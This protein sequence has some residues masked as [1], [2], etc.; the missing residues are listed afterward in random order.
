MKKLFPLKLF[1][2]GCGMVKVAKAYYQSPLGFIEITGTEKG[3]LTLDFLEEVPKVEQADFCLGEALIQLDEYFQG[4]RKEFTLPL[5]L[6]GTEFQK[7][8]WQELQRIPYGETKSYGE[9]AKAIGKQKAA[10]AVGNANNKNK[11]AIFIPCHRVVGSNGSLTGYASGLWRK[12]WLLRHE[13]K[14]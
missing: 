7:I 8:V 5:L 12:E 10:R 9:V 3:I 14:Y 11:L 13:G 1:K 4:K 2:K 6:E